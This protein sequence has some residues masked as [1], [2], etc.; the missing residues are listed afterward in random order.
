ML[1]NQSNIVVLDAHCDAPS[2]M[3]RLRNFGKDNI[4]GQVD[5]PKMKRGG[6]DSSFFALYIPASLEGANATAYAFRLFSEVER[7][8]EANPSAVRFART[9]EEVYSNKANGLISILLGIENS[10]ALN[11]SS[12][13][14]SEFAERGVRYI[15]LTHSADNAAGD[16]CTGN[17]LWGG[18]SSYGKDLVR[19]MNR[20]NVLV[21]VAHAADSTIKDVLSVTDSPIVYTHGCCRALSRHRRNLS[22][23]LIREIAATGGVVGMSIYPPFMSEDFVK[24]LEA[25]G[26][27]AKAW[28]EDEFIKDPS[29]E[30]AARAWYDLQDELQS[31]PRPGVG[32]VVDHIEHAIEVAGIDHVG[33]GTDYDG[34]EVTASGLENIASFGLVFEEMKSRGYSRNELEKVAGGNFLR[35]L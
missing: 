5:F 27:M 9:A 16:S 13:L 30:S 22:D 14:L 32:V 31:L 20:K 34:I 4:R 11:K 26:L 2:Q 24:V 3:L 17:G 23:D 12:E 1:Q 29:N 15:T 35:L 6:V 18:L 21:D 33:L 8:V 25:S 28:V 7:Q 10:S 19:E